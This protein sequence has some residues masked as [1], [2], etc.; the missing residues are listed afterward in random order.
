MY[1]A[2]QEEDLLKCYANGDLGCVLFQFCLRYFSIKCLGGL[3]IEII[4]TVSHAV[5]CVKL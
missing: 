5:K 4:D 1:D 3:K 2:I